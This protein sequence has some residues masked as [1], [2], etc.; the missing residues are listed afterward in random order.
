MWSDRTVI[1]HVGLPAREKTVIRSLFKLVPSLQEGYE[2]VETPKIG[3]A[4]VVFVNADAAH[5]VQAWKRVAQHKPMAVPIM[6]S[7]GDA[8]VAAE[9]G[10]LCL[11]RPLVL[12]KLV[13]ILHQA[14][15]TKAR[16]ET[17]ARRG[18]PRV[19]VVDDSFPVRQYMAHNLPRLAACS[20]C[21][22]LAESAEEARGKL[23]EHSYEVVFL[24]IVMPDID[25][26][27]LCKW[28]KANYKTPVVLLTSKSGS[29][30]KVRGAVA[31]CDSYLTKP[32][33]EA[34]LAGVLNKFIAMPATVA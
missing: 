29:F 1:S 5:A 4:D 32:P 8:E 30:D 6:V 20:L 18:Q 9:H 21:I 23:S 7:G 3:E 14:T 19:L 34:R 27:K 22:D 25:G 12:K 2:L 16:G 31:G 33:D 24:D 15:S 26:Y 11:R 13:D 17:L 28:I 10:G